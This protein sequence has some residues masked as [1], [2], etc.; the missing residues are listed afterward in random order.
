MKLYIATIAAAGSLIC[1]A[2][3][4]QNLDEYRKCWADASTT[5]IDARGISGRT[6]SY[7]VFVADSQCRPAKTEAMATNS[8]S[9]MNWVTEQLVVKLHNAHRAEEMIL[10]DVA[11]TT[12]N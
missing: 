5:V 6:L 12:Q 11:S 7:A 9:V 8:P 2:Q 1:T 3:A 4:D 10:Q